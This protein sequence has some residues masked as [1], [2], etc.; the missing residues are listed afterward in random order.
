MY[1]LYQSQIWRSLQADIYRKPHGFIYLFGKEYFYL[2]KEKKIWP[3]TFREFQVMGLEL[4]DDREKVREELA[5]VKHYFGKKWGNIFFQFG[6]VNEI[7]SF[8]NARAREQDIIGKVRSMRLNNRDQV[9]KE[10][11]MKL[12]FKE[13]MPQSTITIKLA[14]SDEE[15]LTEMN[16]GCADRVKKAIKKGVKVR[17]SDEKDDQTFFEKRQNTAW[18]KGFHTVS[19]EQYTKLLKILRKH[20]RG[21]VFVSELDG[22]LIA[23]SI[24]LFREKTIVYLYGFTDRKYTNIWGHHYLKYGMFERARDHGFEFC[25]LM[26]GAPTGFPEHPLTWVSKFKESLWGMKSEFYGNYDLVLNPLLYYGFKL[27][28]KIKAWI[29]K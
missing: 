7:T 19:K 13:N 16:S 6:I 3:F 2:I 17:L 18:G 12:A 23:G 28:T 14:K 4:P 8:D 5:K 20:G 1:G 24:C 29:K 9:T 25:D 21:N 11:G 27:F 10:T 15:L 22:E 26:G